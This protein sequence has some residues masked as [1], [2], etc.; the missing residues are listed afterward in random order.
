VLHTPHYDLQHEGLHG[1]LSTEEE[2]SSMA[3]DAPAT[4]EH[5]HRQC[6]MGTDH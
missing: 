3:K 4:F 5:G 6:V 1:V 2:C